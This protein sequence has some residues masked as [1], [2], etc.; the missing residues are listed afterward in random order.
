MP[1]VYPELRY[2]EA[3]EKA[4]LRTLLKRRQDITERF[5]N[6]IVSNQSHRL[7]S[8]LP[9]YN[10]SHYS[11][12]NDRHFVRPV[13]KAKRCQNSFINYSVACK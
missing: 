6:Q 8:L 7:H 13:C 10:T 2:I 11:L 12:R 1:I 3:L 5:F 9:K 4:G